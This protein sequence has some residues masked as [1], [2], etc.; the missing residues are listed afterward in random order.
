M[1]PRPHR[2][3]TRRRWRGR[4]ATA[5]LLLACAATRLLAAPDPWEATLEASG[6]A[7]EVAQL[8]SA[9]PRGQGRYR[10][11]AFDPLWADWRALPGAGEAAADRVLRAEGLTALGEAG[12]ALLTSRSQ[13]WSRPLRPLAAP[14][15]PL[16]PLDPDAGAALVAAVAALHTQTLSAVERERLVRA[17][18]GVPAP[19]ARATARLLRA[20]P[21]AVA[22]RDQALRRIQTPPRDLFWPALNLALSGQRSPEAD[23]LLDRLDQ[24][25]LLAGAL[26]LAAA[27]EAAAT[28]LAG[29][30]ALQSASFAFRWETPLGVVALAGAGAQEHPNATYLLLLDTAGDDLYRAGG[31]NCHGDH[32]VALLLDL[33]GNDRYQSVGSGDF[34]VGLLGYG[35][36]LDLAGDD[37]YSGQDMSQGCGIAGVG[38]LLD[39]GG[40]DR[41]EAR[42]QSQG[43][44]VLG[45]GVLGDFAGDDLYACRDESQ[46]FGGVR[47][48]GV[49]VDRAGCDRYRADDEQITRPSPQSK[50]HNTSLAQGAGFGLRSHGFA[51]GLGLLADGA[52]DDS[53]SCGV[54]G[55]GTAYW[56]ALGFLVDRAGDDRYR[57]VWYVQGS[58][59]HYAAAAL[60][61]QAGDDRYLALMTQ[62]QGA[63]HDYG[64]GVF[65]ERS[66]DDRY[67]GAGYT[68]GTGI[69]N[70]IGAFADLSG[71]D[72]YLSRGVHLG[73]V[74]PARPDQTCFGFFFDAGGGDSYPPGSH[75]QPGARWARPGPGGP[76]HLGAGVAGP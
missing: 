33:A 54:F 44:G 10:L 17:A 1:S 40:R 71:K 24:G 7:G 43:S 11:P 19:V 16:A 15:A 20:V 13:A 4:A 9:R 61:D 35:L 59:A 46:G 3:P 69:W 26:P 8:S 12:A 64:L 27:L 39:R 50:E 29:V 22:A 28:E 75:A 72:T 18:E 36:H 56:F 66:G 73:E 32:P 70:G 67:E 57:G 52:G 65:L 58:T 14:L 63:G 49:L 45:L 55:Q 38:L 76:D 60:I 6:R 21:A 41:Y 30:A 62:S 53:Y 42:K 34:G 5:S 37:A 74:G 68:Q 31:G 47:G 25:A 23:A 48:A 2:G 51:G